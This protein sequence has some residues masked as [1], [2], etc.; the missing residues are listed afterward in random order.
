MEF[1]LNALRNDVGV[2]NF[3]HYIEHNKSIKVYTEH[4]ETRLLTY[5]TSP[6]VKLMVIIEEIP[7][8]MAIP[9]PN[10]PIVDLYPINQN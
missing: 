7:D 5:F 10:S 2:L 6:K 9:R 8:E 1:G 3:A 4:S